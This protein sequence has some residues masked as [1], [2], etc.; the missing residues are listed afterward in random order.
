MSN[1]GIFVARKLLKNNSNKCGRIRACLQRIN[2][3]YENDVNATLNHN[4]KV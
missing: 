2:H 4:G 1:H 3:K